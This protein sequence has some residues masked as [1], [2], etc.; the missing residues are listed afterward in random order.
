MLSKPLWALRQVCGTCNALLFSA[1]ISNQLF[2]NQVNKIYKLL[3]YKYYG[4]K[5]IYLYHTVLSPW[6][7]L[8]FGAGRLDGFIPPCHVYCRFSL[9]HF[10]RSRALCLYAKYARYAL[11]AF[12]TITYTQA[13]VGEEGWRI[14]SMYTLW[15]MVACAHLTK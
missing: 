9:T 11:V 12:I 7:L 2:N 14:V 1:I 15:R 3:N 5:N 10:R 4:N 8:C 6:Y 13:G